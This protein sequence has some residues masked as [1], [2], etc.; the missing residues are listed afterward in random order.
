M[1]KKES[2]IHLRV[3]NEHKQLIR[4]FA[5]SKE[6]TISSFLLDAAL[7]KIAREQTKRKR[8]EEKTNTTVDM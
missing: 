8:E 6:L 4:A 3:S 2:I 1:K 5:E 7:K